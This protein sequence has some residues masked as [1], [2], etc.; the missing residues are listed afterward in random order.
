MAI[1]TIAQRTSFLNKFFLSFFKKSVL[2]GLSPNNRH[3]L[4][5]DGHGSHVNLEVIEQAHQFSLNMITLP[6]PCFATFKCEFFS[7]LQKNPK[8]RKKQ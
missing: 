1:Q 4:A 2:G 7:A 6:S 5:L 3:L 8:K